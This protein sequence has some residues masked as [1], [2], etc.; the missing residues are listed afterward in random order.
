MEPQHPDCG[1]TRPFVACVSLT[2][3]AA[4]SCTPGAELG[5]AEQSS[6]R[7]VEIGGQS[8][9]AA[10]AARSP[11]ASSFTLFESGQVRPLALSPD[12]HHLFVANTPDNRLE[13]FRIEGHRLL[14]TGSVP[15]GHEPVAV[16]ARSDREVWVVNHRPD[17]VS[18]VAL[19]A[20]ADASRVVRTRQRRIR[21]RPR[22]RGRA[23]PPIGDAALRLLA[24]FR[25]V[26]FTC[27]PP[28]SGERLGVDRDGDGDGVWDGDERDAHTDPADPDSTP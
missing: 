10:P 14:H 25:A 18:V 5:G 9:A 17:S 6:Q 11:D 8:A 3:A 28:G 23:A 13:L 21:L 1:A 16:A 2:V 27:V 15:V 22:G 12:R 20:G 7:D 19:D 26:T 4:L 24:R